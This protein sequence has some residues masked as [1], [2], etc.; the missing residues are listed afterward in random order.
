LGN[1]KKHGIGHEM[2]NTIEEFNELATMTDTAEECLESL[3]FGSHWV[4]IAVL[5]KKYGIKTFERRE[6]IRAARK[7]L[8]EFITAYSAD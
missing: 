6:A 2:I 3:R 8:N 4:L 1:S 5:S 7:I